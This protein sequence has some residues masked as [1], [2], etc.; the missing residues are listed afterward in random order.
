MKNASFAFFYFV[1]G[2]WLW[3]TDAT[4]QTWAP[5]A[6]VTVCPEE[7]GS[8]SL[9]SIPTNFRFAAGI[10]PSTT[11]GRLLNFPAISSGSATFQVRWEDNPSGG[12]LTVAFERGDVDNNGNTNWTRVT[13]LE[14]VALIRSVAFQPGP[15]GGTTIPYCSTAPFTITVAPETFLNVPKEQIPAYLWEV[16]AAWGVQ[17]ATLIPS[18]PTTPSNFRVY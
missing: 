10:P 1:F 7:T 6:T 11:G 13:N 18:F 9:T 4:A 17:G 16:P 2:L 8:Y 14:L 12:K 5:A 3:S 15:G